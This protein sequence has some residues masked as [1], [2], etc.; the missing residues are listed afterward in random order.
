MPILGNG[1]LFLGRRSP[2]ISAHEEGIREYLTNLEAAKKEHA[3][4]KPR[5]D[6]LTLD[7][8]LGLERFC[9]E[10]IWDNRLRSVMPV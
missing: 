10:C 6:I 9:G 3:A 2:R 7:P 8:I 5:Y 4:I 1:D